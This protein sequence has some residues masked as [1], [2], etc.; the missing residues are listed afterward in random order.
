MPKL[1]PNR[2]EKAGDRVKRRGRPLPKGT[3]ASMGKEAGWRLG[4]CCVAWDEP[5]EPKICHLSELEKVDA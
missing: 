4:W 2:P 1:P 5:G 3:L